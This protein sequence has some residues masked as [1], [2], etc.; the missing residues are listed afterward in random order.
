LK[1]HRRAAAVQN[2]DSHG[3]GGVPFLYIVSLR[4]SAGRRF[5]CMTAARAKRLLQ[6][7]EPQRN[8]VEIQ[9]AI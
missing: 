3:L 2:Q 8:G 5:G 9:V 1:L 4:R 6:Y 7:P